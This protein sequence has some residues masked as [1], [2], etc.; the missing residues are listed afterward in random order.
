MSSSTSYKLSPDEQQALKQRVLAA[1]RVQRLREV[2]AQDRRLAKERVRAYQGLCIDSAQQLQAQLVCLITQQREQ[3]LAVLQAQYEDALAGLAAAQQQAAVTEQELALQ[4]QQKHQLYLQRQAEAQGRFAAALAQV[5]NARQA[6]LQAVLDR[7]QRRQQVMAQERGK[8]AGFAEQ[9]KEAAA[10]QVQRQAEL[11]LQEEQR[12]RQNK[13]SR[14]D[15]KYSR[16]HELGV[17]HLV[18]NHRELPQQGADAASQAQQEADRYEGLV[19]GYDA[20]ICICAFV[21][22]VAQHSFAVAAMPACDVCV[23]CVSTPHDDVLCA[24]PCRLRE[25]QRVQEQQQQ[26]NAC[27]AA[28]RGVTAQRLLQAE[29]NRRRMEQALQE[30]E[31][32]EVQQRKQDLAPDKLTAA[33][34]LR[35]WHKQKI[36]AK[37]CVA[38]ER[39]FLPGSTASGQQGLPSFLTRDD[40][41]TQQQQ[42]DKEQQQRVQQSSAHQTATAADRA[43]KLVQEL[44]RQRRAEAAAA[45]AEQQQRQQERERLARAVAAAGSSLLSVDSEVPVDDLITFIPPVSSADSHQLPATPTLASDE[46]VVAAAEHAALAAA[47]AADTSTASQLGG[48]ST[49]LT[50][51]LGDSQRTSTASF[52]QE[53]ERDSSFRQS[54]ASSAEEGSAA[55]TESASAHAAAAAAA[56]S[57]Q[58]QAALRGSSVGATAST[59]PGTSEGGSADSST[60]SSP[61]AAVSPGEAAA[62]FSSRDS[63]DAI[64]AAADEVLRQLPADMQAAAAARVAAGAA[65]AL[66]L[67]QQQ[68]AAGVTAGLRS[69]AEQSLARP[70]A[71]AGPSSSGRP[72]ESSAEAATILAELR[73][74]QQ[75]LGVQVKKAAAVGG[76]KRDS[77]GAVGSIFL[78]YTQ[79][80]ALV[81]HRADLQQFPQ[82]VVDACSLLCCAAAAATPP[83]LAGARLSVLIQCPGRASEL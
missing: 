53:S 2:R 24:C 1:L 67:E 76:G 82:Y 4:A 49:A 17:P 7:V 74:L 50:D 16:L 21:L 22:S 12:R 48:G 26:E 19:L 63:L 11:N 54:L 14:I 45:A 6:E 75:Q 77:K 36:Q 71:Q 15:F 73:A 31:S 29:Q 27:K 3:E 72:A 42:G 62:V 18:V 34:L 8:A 47:S 64:I 20:R 70:A 69:S 44:E 41:T 65:P 56:A 57:E 39:D 25:E 79:T 80:S 55:E 43:L 38:F 68:Q 30:L 28:E 13:V 40:D 58:Y 60:P 59:V 32:S 35:K 9:A 5:R 51:L 37:A 83:S 81:C 52:V 46:L 66:R 33:P 61:A 23:T 10:R 78:R